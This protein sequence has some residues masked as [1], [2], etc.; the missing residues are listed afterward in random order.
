MIT[1]DDLSKENIPADLKRMTKNKTPGN[2]SLSKECY[3]NFWGGL[4]DM[5]LNSQIQMKKKKKKSLSNKTARGER[6]R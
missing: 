5:L 1:E 2:D 6:Q 4:K 3:Q